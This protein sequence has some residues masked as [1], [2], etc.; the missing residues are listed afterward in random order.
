MVK[1]TVEH[2]V[3]MR[4]VG[5]IMTKGRVLQTRFPISLIALPMMWTRSNMDMPSV[6][7][8]LQTM[9]VDARLANPLASWMQHHH[10][11]WMRHQMD[12]QKHQLHCHFNDQ[13][14]QIKQIQG[15]MRTNFLVGTRNHRGAFTNLCRMTG[16]AAAK[17]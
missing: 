8:D 11:H 1:P 16:G 5:C 4:W 9:K 10:W 13:R 14:L 6:D 7:L 15:T 3:T 2:Y 12:Q 17:D